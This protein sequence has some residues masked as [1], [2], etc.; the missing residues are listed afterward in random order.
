MGGVGTASI[1]LPSGVMVGALAV[2]NAFGDIIDHESGQILSG[3]RAMKGKGWLDTSRAIEQALLSNPASFSAIENTTLA[4]VATDAAL[5]KAEAQRVAMMA[6]DGLARTIRPV[7]TMFDG[8]TVFAIS[9]GNLQADVTTV[10]SVAADLL[11]RAIAR[12]GRRFNQR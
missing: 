3:A 6:H 2:V 9:T 10:G 7:H 11:A 4:V 8:D 5:T 1:K 12:V